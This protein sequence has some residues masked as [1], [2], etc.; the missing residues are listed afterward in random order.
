M[1]RGKPLRR[2]RPMKRGRPSKRFAKRRDPEYCRWIRTLPCC[3]T[4][5]VTGEREVGMV[6]HRH[7]SV[8]RFVVEAAHVVSR[9]AGGDDRGNVVP[10]DFMLHREQHAIGI[11]SFQE[12]YGLDLAALATRLEREYERTMSLTGG[13]GNMP[14]YTA[15]EREWVKRLLCRLNADQRRRYEEACKTAPRHHAS[16]KLYD[17]AKAEIAERILYEDSLRGSA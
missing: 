12:K 6:G 7:L 8:R 2:T 17:R 13:F 3:V 15:Q 4:G 5:K 1:K 14:R 10:L 9:G 11:K 16:G